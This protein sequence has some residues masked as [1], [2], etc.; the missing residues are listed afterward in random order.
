M[1]ISTRQVLQL[2]HLSASFG[3]SGGGLAVSNVVSNH[4]HG[5]TNSTVDQ[6]LTGTIG[7]L[8]LVTNNLGLTEGAAALSWG[9]NDYLA[10]QTTVRGGV[11]A[12]D[13]RIKAAAETKIGLTDS[14]GTFT[15]TFSH[16]SGLKHIGANDTYKLA[17]ETLDHV[18]GE[19][20]G[21]LTTV[22]A[23]ANLSADTFLEVYNAYTAISGNAS[24]SYALR[25]NDS[26][27]NV[28]NSDGQW[29]AAALASGYT[30][31]LTGSTSLTDAL[32]D[33]DHLLAEVSGSAAA[34]PNLTG[35][36][37]RATNLGT[38]TGTII[39]NNTSIK[40]ALQELETDAVAAQTFLGVN[41][42]VV[43]FVGGI[44]SVIPRG[45][46]VSS[47][48]AALETDLTA[49]QTLLGKPAES[50]NL[51]TFSGDILSDTSTV[52]AALQALETDLQGV[53]TLL[54]V[55]AETT[56]FNNFDGDVIP[57]NSTVSGALLALETR[58]DA[59]KPD[60]RAAHVSGSDGD[61]FSGYAIGFGSGGPQMRLVK[62]HNGFVD[63]FFEIR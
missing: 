60:F 18:A 25:L 59:I 11:E 3:L 40:T 21:T 10:D 6:V 9:T 14:G 1:A 36:P 7:R 5:W 23:S 20:S 38:F 19:V 12:L 52:Q 44:G 4:G 34:L 63:V 53:Q 2:R 55:A 45:A 35:R 49:L 39:T 31:Y 51:G 27:G 48:I 24:T 56:S 22:L 43:S 8:D 17:I 30:N 32:H 16:A 26:F 54:G 61:V 33:I 46:T 37:D 62:K 28:I 41:P 50:T 13:Q 42:E 29:S 47:S 57:N 15:N 58:V